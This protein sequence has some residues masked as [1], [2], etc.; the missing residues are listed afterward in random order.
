MQGQDEVVNGEFVQA[1]TLW[2][3]DGA[4]KGW[5]GFSWSWVTNAVHHELVEVRIGT[6]F[7][8]PAADTRV[9]VLTA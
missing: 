5:T 6:I 4:V 2:L 3:L 9:A 1:A 7:D 8:K